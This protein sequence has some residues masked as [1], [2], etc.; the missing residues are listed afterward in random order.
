MIMKNK[1]LIIAAHPDDEAIGC[2]GTIIKHKKNGDSIHL[3][4]MTD[5]ISARRATK[6]SKLIRN[7]GLKKCL[8]ILKPDSYQCFD[9]PDNEMDKF[10]LLKV[11]K[12][13]EKFLNNIKPNIVYTHSE[14]D[15][16]VDHQVVAKAV[17]TATRPFPEQPVKELY[18]FFI[19]SSSEW[20]FGNGNTAPD[21]Y[22]D[23][24]DQIKDKKDLLKAYESEM[25]DP[26]HARSIDNILNTN[27]VCGSICGTN[28]AEAFKVI[29]ILK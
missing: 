22:V 23:I 28:F 3:I 26:P 13:I 24:S 20:N 21:F 12:E 14:F 5:G 11:V 1:V 15:L 27:K 7:K 18:S 19:N 17:K 6:K 25:R 29:R 4:F 16:N 8:Q 2:G 10:S 9:F